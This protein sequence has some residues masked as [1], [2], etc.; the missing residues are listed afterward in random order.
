[1]SAHVVRVYEYVNRPYEAV[2]E[3]LKLDAVG[4]FQRATA[5]ATARARALVSTMRASVGP[6]E[7]GVEVVVRVTAVQEAPRAPYGPRTRLSLAWRAKERAE[8]FPTM[9]A[10]L[11]VYPLGP[12]ETQLEL[13]GE[14]RPPLGIVGD[15]L[16][17]VVG[18]RIADA[19]V[20]RFV[21]EIAERLRIDVP[22]GA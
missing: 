12:T 9:E 4:V 2:G 6:L 22:S 19:A 10:M 21:Q 15:V 8:L 5:S 14:Y 13:S 20:H 18:H 3:L 17:A 1:M 7:L 11:D 16:D